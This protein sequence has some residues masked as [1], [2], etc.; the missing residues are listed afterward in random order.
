MSRPRLKRIVMSVSVLAILVSVSHAMAMSNV[1]PRT[2][3]PKQVETVNT[4]EIKKEAPK[5]P[6]NA[7]EAK[8]AEV[9]PEPQPTPTPPPVDPNGC[10]AKGMWWRADNY[11]C[12]PKNIPAPVQQQVAAQPGPS[13]GSGSRQAEISKYNWGQGV[14]LAV[15]SAESGLNPGIVNYNPATKDHSVGCFQINI[16]GANAASRPSEAALKDAATNVAFAHKIYTSNG[17]S[18]IGQWGVCRGKVSCY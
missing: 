14:A 17:N 11:E 12:I 18:F 13:Y 7:P 10:E 16:W 8:P 5:Q 6:E 15:A 4:T 1:S 3:T 2:E 9:A